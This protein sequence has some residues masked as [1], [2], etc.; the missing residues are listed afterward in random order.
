M[1]CR[2]I[3]DSLP[4]YLEGLLSPEE[5]ARVRDHL[6]SCPQCRKAIADL[7]RMG[8]ILS[9][10]EEVTPPPWL[11]QRIMTRVRDEAQPEKGFFRRL[12]SP[13]HL[14]IPLSTAA[15][16]ILSVL[17]FQV[18]RTQETQF[19]RDGDLH[20]AL[21]KPALERSMGTQ[22]PSRKDHSRAAIPPAPAGGPSVPR[23][24]TPPSAAKSAKSPQPGLVQPTHQS[25]L[26]LEQASPPRPDG[27]G[28]R[29]SGKHLS[30]EEDA[31]KPRK[32]AVALAPLPLETLESVGS[33]KAEEPPVFAAPR[34]SLSGALSPPMARKKSG[35]GENTS[36]SAVTD[37]GLRG[38]S[39]ST[40]EI[41]SLLRQFDASRIERR[42]SGGMEILTAELPP[43]QV[44]ALLQRL[45]GLGIT[46]RAVSIGTA[47]SRAGMVPVRIE[48][49]ANR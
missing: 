27:E 10:L 8:T 41:I 15:L 39:A 44:Q 21:P 3:E 2:D 34:P 42:T 14:K 29:D 28:M 32:G 11:K 4:A 33:R 40:A 17:A 48:V 12:F 49:P 38:K 23:E 13:L 26:R 35:D 31:A 37:S 47:D 1:T 24:T 36:D 25:A 18:Y 16:L 30:G 9:G 46:G 45:T 6:A 19:H 5:S 43:R 20:V 7:E 22:G